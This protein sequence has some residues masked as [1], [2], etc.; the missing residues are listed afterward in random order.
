MT[1]NFRGLFSDSECFCS[2][3]QNNRSISW[4]FFDTDA[5]RG[6]LIL[7]LSVCGAVCKGLFLFLC[8]WGRTTTFSTLEA[9]SRG[10]IEL[11]KLFAIKRG[12]SSS[13]PAFIL[14]LNRSKRFPIYSPRARFEDSLEVDDINKRLH[15]CLKASRTS[16]SSAVSGRTLCKSRQS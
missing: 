6:V 4:K 10:L 11:L 5:L 1:S 12:N 2:E 16:G 14:D 13:E 8:R 15:F 3:K 9:L 7:E